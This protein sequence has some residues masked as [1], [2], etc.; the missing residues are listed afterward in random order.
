MTTKDELL[1][2]IEGRP[3]PEQAA[4][5]MSMAEGD[6]EAFFSEGG[7][8]DTAGKT[9][10]QTNTEGTEGKKQEQQE[11]VQGQ[12]GEGKGAEPTEA[13]LNPDNAVILAKDRKHTIGYEK[14]VEARENEKHWKA[15][16]EA[17]KAQADAAQA[18]IA[19][20]QA[21]ADARAKAGAAPT[22]TDAN[23]AAAQAAIAQG[24]DPALFG[25]FSEEDLAKGINTLVDMKVEAKVNALLDQRL[26]PLQQKQAQDATADHYEAI[27][28]A[29]PDADSIAES[30]ELA[31]WIASQPSFAR[32]GYSKVL[33]SGTTEQVIELFSN[34]KQATG[35][36][37][38]P[39][40]QAAPES[41][42]AA[43]AKALEQATAAPPASLSDIPGGKPPSGNRF[44][45]ISQM[46]GAGMAAALGEM[47][48]EQ[49]EAFLNRTI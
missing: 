19:E 16:A 15:Q 49:I 35:A 47:T 37:T 18:K 32:D 38:K 21:L 44:E 20:L 2:S 39:E 12:G 43:A 17:A 22:T 7:V 10:D 34:F 27:Y 8:P 14:L 3:T 25:D 30:K 11:P 29:H 24:A 48:P 5:L 6:T 4:M 45:V 33:Q 28:K 9:Q 26:A 1:Q 46:D 36:A 41:A 23:L 40:Q 13:E 42:K 31:E